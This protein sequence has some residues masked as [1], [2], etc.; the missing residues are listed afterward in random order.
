MKTNQKIELKLSDSIVELKGD[1]KLTSIKL[2][3]GEELEIDGLFIAIGNTPS[4]DMIKG[5]LSLSEGGFII[6]DENL[7]TDKEGVYA[8]GD[9]I[10]KKL[11]QVV[12]AV[13]DGAVAVAGI[14][15]EI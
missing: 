6:T 7:K 12:T 1:D 3:S 13:N 2:K 15:E 11:R 8:A 4:T 9:V 14:L 5:Q 10:V